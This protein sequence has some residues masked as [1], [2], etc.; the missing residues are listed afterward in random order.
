MFLSFY[1]LQVDLNLDKHLVVDYLE[2]NLAFCLEHLDLLL[3][4]ESNFVELLY[5]K[6]MVDKYYKVREID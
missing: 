2:V 4:P 1:I 6:G 3:M 5:R